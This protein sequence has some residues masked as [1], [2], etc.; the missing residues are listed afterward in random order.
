M[1]WYLFSERYIHF[2]ITNT[3]KYSI[4]LLFI[5][6]DFYQQK[7]HQYP[8]YIYRP[9]PLTC[10]PSFNYPFH[11]PSYFK[12]IKINQ[13][14]LDPSSYRVTVR[15]ITPLHVAVAAAEAYRAHRHEDSNKIHLEPFNQ[16]IT[17][18][19]PTTNLYENDY[20][21]SDS[22]I[23]PSVPFKKIIPKN[24]GIQVSSTSFITTT[25]D[26]VIIS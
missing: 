5:L 3:K 22:Q 15:R 6:P 24:N 7:Q 9:M 19:P 4:N 8:S 12:K 2:D 13:K 25:D 11:E 21:N 17:S 10:N 1:Q 26:Q 16:I 20:L 23:I 18:P 14:S